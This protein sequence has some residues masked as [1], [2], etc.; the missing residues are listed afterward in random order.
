MRGCRRHETKENNGEAH[1]LVQAMME[2]METMRRQND[3]RLEE[4]RREQEHLRRENNQIDPDFQ[5]FLEEIL[6]EP[7]PTSSVFPKIGAF[8]GKQDH[9]AHMKTFKTQILICGGPDAVKCKMFASI[10][11]GI[12]LDRFSSLSEGSIKFFGSF[13]QD[14]EEDGKG[15]Q[16]C[17]S[18][19][20][21]VGWIIRQDDEEDD[22]GDKKHGFPMMVVGYTKKVGWQ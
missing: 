19:M 15:D 18:P 3:E 7:I 8:A 9:V 17:R 22:K 11:V 16:M 10:L 20:M 21:M 14:G 1:D 5:P 13:H 6:R 2:M 12:A 4:V